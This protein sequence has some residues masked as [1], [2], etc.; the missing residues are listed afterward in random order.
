MLLKETPEE[1]R[2]KVVLATKCQYRA[3]FGFIN[4]NRINDRRV[5]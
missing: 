5:H 3:S 4:L 2:K 1:E